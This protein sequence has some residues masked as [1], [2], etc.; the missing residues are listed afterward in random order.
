MFGL[1]PGGGLTGWLWAEEWRVLE[2]GVGECVTNGA[3]L[4]RL[5]RRGQNWILKQQA[6]QRKV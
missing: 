5:Q 3:R 6:G 4:R 1:V 2:G